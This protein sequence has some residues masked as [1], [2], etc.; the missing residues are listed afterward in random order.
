MPYVAIC[1]KIIRDSY[2]MVVQRMVMRNELR[3]VIAEQA[4]DM[5]GERFFDQGEWRTRFRRTRANHPDADQVAEGADVTAHR[6]ALLEGYHFRTRRERRI[7]ELHA[8]G[9]TDGA[10]AKRMKRAKGAVQRVIHRVERSIYGDAMVHSF[11][12]LRVWQHWLH[13]KEPSDIARR[14]GVSVGD[15]DQVVRE[16]IREW[17]RRP[18]SSRLGVLIMADDGCDAGF[19]AKLGNL[20]P[21]AVLAAAQRDPEI[22]EMLQRLG[23]TGEAP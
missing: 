22:A 16:A 23:L 3:A 10:I 20:T 18:P 13:G 11:S 21:A 19:V 1:G 4:A 14:C 12:A 2:C 9:H 6:E 15:V 17:R 8:A 5:A 7:Y